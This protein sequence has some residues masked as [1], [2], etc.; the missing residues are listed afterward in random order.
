MKENISDLVSAFDYKDHLDKFSDLKLS[1]HY[2]FEDDVRCK[3][4]NVEQAVKV[5]TEQRPI[6]FKINEEDNSLYYSVDGGA[7]ENLFDIDV[8]ASFSKSN[9]WLCDKLILVSNIF[10]NVSSIDISDEQV[11]FY[12]CTVIASVFGGFFKDD[13]VEICKNYN[14]ETWKKNSEYSETFLELSTAWIQLGSKY[15]KLVAAAAKYTLL[16]ERKKKQVPSAL[17]LPEEVDLKLNKCLNDL[18]KIR[19][20]YDNIKLSDS[21]RS[22]MKRLEIKIMIAERDEALNARMKE[23]SMI[24]QVIRLMNL[25]SNNIPPDILLRINRTSQRSSLDLYRKLTGKDDYPTSIE[26]KF[27][28]KKIE[29]KLKK[30]TKRAYLNKLFARESEKFKQNASNY[31]APDFV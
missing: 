25:N 1:E 3:I 20:D 7:S 4:K 18:A 26:D 9:V 16:R 2:H 31:V 10:P 13:F 28:V 17:Q 12:V 29:N 6:I 11:S 30:E 27:E 19:F 8:E 14:F 23:D 15:I 5:I 22:N 24:Y 21:N